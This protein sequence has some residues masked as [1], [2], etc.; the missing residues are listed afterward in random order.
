MKLN[1]IQ[2]GFYGGLIFAIG[3]TSYRYFVHGELNFAGVF[4]GFIWFL[5]SVIFNFRRVKNRK[6]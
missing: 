6:D 3:Y 2:Q 4:A 5:F 1:P